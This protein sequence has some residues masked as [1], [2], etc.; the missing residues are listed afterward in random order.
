[1]RSGQPSLG[2]QLR[3]WLFATCVVAGLLIAWEARELIDLCLAVLA[4]VGL[5]VALWVV[6][7]RRAKKRSVSYPELKTD[8]NRWTA[9]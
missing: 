8:T 7:A 1:M 9:R 5:V 3:A 2:E 6:R 4:L